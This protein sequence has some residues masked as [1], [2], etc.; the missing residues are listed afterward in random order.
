MADPLSLRLA[1]ESAKERLKQAADDG[2][3]VDILAEIDALRWQ[4]QQVDDVEDPE[5]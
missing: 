4:L 5:A 2:E 3:H 1:L